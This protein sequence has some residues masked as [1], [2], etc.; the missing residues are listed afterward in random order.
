MKTFSLFKLITLAVVCVFT[1]NIMSQEKIASS[2]SEYN[3]L[4][5]NANPGDVIILKD[6]IWKD[7]KLNAYGKGEKE[8]PIIIKAE[9]PGKVIISG[10]STLNIYGEHII[11]SG[12]WFKNGDSSY[13]SVV[14]FRKDA[15]TFANHCRFTNSTISYY[16]VKDD[17]KDHWVDIWGKNNRV[18]HNNFTGKT[19]EGTTL[20]VW[21]KGEEHLE[22][23]H[24]IDNNIFGARPDLGKNGGETIRI[25]TS[26]N[27]MK[28]S[29][30]IVEKN[31]FANCDGEIEIISNKSCDNIFR[32]NL[33]V[34]SK[35]T[36]TL[37]HGNNALVERNVFL[38][39][40]VKKTGGIRIIN[41]GHVVRNN[42][43]IGLEGD[44]YRGAIVVM[45]GVPNSPLNRYH[46]VENV[47]IQNNTI[48]NSGP[49]SFGEGKDSEKTL[50]PKN[51][52]FS[53][54]VIYNQS[55]SNNV[56]FVDDISGIK[57]Q[58]N[59]VDGSIGITNNGFKTIKI[60]WENIKSFLVPT[61]NNN[62]LLETSTNTKSPEK[63]INK[64]VRN[65]FNA[66]AFNLGSN[67]LPKALKLRAGPGWKPNIIAPVIKPA[68][69]SVTPGLETLR[70]AISKAAPGST[71]KLQTGEYIL[72]KKITVTNNISIVGDK[73]GA[74]IISVKK[75]IEK[76]L[77]Y[78]FRLNEGANLKI[79]HIIFDGEVSQPK[80][81]FSSPDKKED[82]LYNLHVDN[83]VFRN[84]TNKDGGSIFKA[85]N[86]TKADTLSFKNS[87][88]EN[89]Y[90]GLNLSYD[91][92]V[93][94]FYNANVILLENSVFK[95]IDEAAVNYIR[96]TPTVDLPGGKLLVKNCVFSNI[97]NQEKGKVLR[98]NG[99]HSVEITNTVFENSF[100]IKSPVDLK[101]RF[102]YI[103]N[104]LVHNSGVVKASKGA[105]MENVLYKNPKWDDNELFIPNEKSPLLK[106]KNKVARI[107]LKQ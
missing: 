3:L 22:N 87:R 38:G 24:K 85:Y 63:D 74:S 34:A 101:G 67:K 96:K 7:V 98:V 43:L 100:K 35:G 36:L 107:G 57:F 76:P 104:S 66:G 69:I 9:T 52:N 39:N 91:K 10:N 26:T 17:I 20:V 65:P 55:S 28:S 12:L 81:A 1:N 73:G 49:I 92:D 50:A 32:D 56:I 16:K 33:F 47:D 88:F 99:I 4:I 97:Y 19:S 62:H 42:L 14:Q 37:R 6:G 31:I 11:V 93:T 103:K 53:N 8:N 83:V 54:N 15:K 5:K 71:L 90:R 45:N 60:D 48:I 59:Y 89:S 13:K 23:N 84:F 21:L 27:S 70:K 77:T 30:T 41:K 79:S 64:T 105:V 86:G 102:S 51:V 40:G 25:G 95:N 82:G 78:M 58:N 75:N 44:G 68:D 94:G 29:K 18:D 80:Y 46:Q 61:I 72:E 2:I 106:E